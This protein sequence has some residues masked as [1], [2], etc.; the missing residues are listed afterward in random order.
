MEFNYT[1]CS[2]AELEDIYENIDKEKY[3]EKFKHI[4]ELISERRNSKEQT[5]EDANYIEESKGLE[6]KAG[7]EKAIKNGFIAAIFATGM[8]FIAAIIGMYQ[9]FESEY[10]KYFNDPAV[11]IDI[12]IMGL[13]AF[14]IYK[15]SRIASTLM[16]LYYLSAKISLWVVD[17]QPKGLIMGAIIL[18]LLFNAM[19]AT[20]KWHSTH[21]NNEEAPK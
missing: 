4:C 7:C 19:C 3:P 8:S 13:L 2:L 18:Y 16:F 9:S 1:K 20:F 5:V 15:K 12:T 21:K 17:L 6:S 11:F 10:L 14:Y